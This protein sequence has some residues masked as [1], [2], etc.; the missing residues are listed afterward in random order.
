MSIENSAGPAKHSI[1]NLDKTKTLIFQTCW[2]RHQTFCLS[3][4]SLLIII[5]KLLQHNTDPTGGP[6]YFKL[7]KT[8]ARTG[9]ST[10]SLE[11]DKFSCSERATTAQCSGQTCFS[12]FCWLRRRG[13]LTMTKLVATRKYKSKTLSSIK[14]CELVFFRDGQ[15]TLGERE[16]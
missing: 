15:E 1:T 4:H 10:S 2:E 16:R 3:L 8:R 6:N 14:G 11:R 5:A 13:G 9:W 12:L 7:I